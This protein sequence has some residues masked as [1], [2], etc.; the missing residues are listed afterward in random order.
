MRQATAGPFVGGTV[1]SPEPLLAAGIRHDLVEDQAQQGESA[2]DSSLGLRTERG[3]RAYRLARRCD[4]AP[5]NRSLGQP[6]VELP[7]H[8]VR[9][10]PSGE[11]PVMAPYPLKMLAM[12]GLAFDA[13]T[14]A[15]QAAVGQLLEESIGSRLGREGGGVGPLQWRVQ[16]DGCGQI[17][18]RIPHIERSVIETP[19]QAM[20]VQA[21]GPEP[22]LY[23]LGG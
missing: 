20:S 9:H 6:A 11:G 12:I 10:G 1:A 22:R 17:R 16:F 19:S 14:R 18:G 2:A 3:A 13:D 21:L 5:A 4:R 8:P 7:A 23:V 15:G